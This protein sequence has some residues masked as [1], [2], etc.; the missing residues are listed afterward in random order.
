[1]ADAATKK[2][3]ISVDSED[4]QQVSGSG[5]IPG[6]ASEVTNMVFVYP[7]G[8]HQDESPKVWRDPEGCD[9]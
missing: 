8:E 2:V 1:M 5:V 6:F 7:A 9:R 4:S 3:F